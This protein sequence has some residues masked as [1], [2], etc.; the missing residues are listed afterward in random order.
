M[1]GGRRSGEET[2]RKAKAEI[3]RKTEGEE[4]NRGGEF[5]RAHGP[6]EAGVGVGGGGAGAESGCGGCCG[7]RGL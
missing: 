7:L 3:L 5:L 2:D 4:T 6:R 1:G